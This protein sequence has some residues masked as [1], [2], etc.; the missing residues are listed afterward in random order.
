MVNSE[1]SAEKKYA[2]VLAELECKNETQEQDISY[3][4]GV[5]HLQMSIIFIS[6]C[7]TFLVRA[8]MNAS[9]VAMT[10]VKTDVSHN[11]VNITVNDTNF[12]PNENKTYEDMP[13]DEYFLQENDTSYNQNITYVNNINMNTIINES[14]HQNNTWSVNR[15][16]A[17]P[18]STQEMVLGSFFLGYM[19]M[20]SPIGL[21]CQRWG[22]KLPLQISLFT[23]GFITFCT[24]WLALIGDYKAVC[25]ARVAVGLCQAGTYPG[26]HTLIAKWIPVSERAKFT[27]YVYAGPMIGTILAYHVSGFLS[28]SRHGWPSIFWLAGILCI[29]MGFLLTWMVAPSP[30]QHPSVSEREKNYILGGVKDQTEKRYPTPWKAIMRSVPVW[31]CF[32]AHVGSGTVFVFMF[33]QIP[34]Y[35]HHGAGMNLKNSGLLSSLPYIGN[36]FVSIFIGW[37]SEYCI[38]K[39]YL[40]TRNVRILSNCLATVGPAIGLFSLTFVHNAIFAVCCMT[41]STAVMAGTHTGW[42]VNYIDL[43][44]NFSGTLMATGNTLM[45]LSAVLLPVLVSNVVRDLTNLLQW[46]IIVFIVGT[47]GLITNVI[48]AV[49]MSVEVQPWNSPDYELTGQDEPDEQ[50]GKSN[51][52]FI[53]D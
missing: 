20:M 31:A 11:E 14:D 45:N 39:N 46:R 33:T 1:T 40:S 30:Q 2:E 44:P 3:G 12:D 15:V 51:V 4:Y 37:A 16:Y 18:K 47:I 8:Q 22:G 6:L 28:V 34:T 26:V 48:Y 32:V 24:P 35:F 49:F 50:N 27:S 13:Q 41:L 7:V 21:V 5:R 38:N 25:M 10:D 42:M 36:F 43:S 53:K 29:L 52:D 17:W 9:I 19:L 23:S